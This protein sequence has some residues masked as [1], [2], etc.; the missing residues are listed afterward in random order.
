MIPIRP[1]IVPLIAV[2]GDTRQVTCLN[3]TISTTCNYMD[4]CNTNS[5]LKLTPPLPR[6]RSKLNEIFQLTRTGGRTDW[7]DNSPVNMCYNT[8]DLNLSHIMLLAWAIYT[9][10][11]SPLPSQ[12][13]GQNQVI[14]F[15]I[16]PKIIPWSLQE[17]ESN[18]EKVVLWQLS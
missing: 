15:E 13:T 7:A 6:E 18:F 14:L 4:W 17:N 8:D 10:L 3:K 5:Y 2:T 12:K 11:T 16:F 1:Y 9:Q